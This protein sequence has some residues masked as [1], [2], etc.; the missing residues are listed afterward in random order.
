MEG[1]LLAKTSVE[2]SIVKAKCALFPMVE[3][4][5]VPFTETFKPFVIKITVGGV[6]YSHAYCCMKRELGID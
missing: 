1:D 4:D 6:C 5:Q 3:L 2:V